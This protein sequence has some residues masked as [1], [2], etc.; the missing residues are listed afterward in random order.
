[1]FPGRSTVAE[2]LLLLHSRHKPRVSLITGVTRPSWISIHNTALKYG[3]NI[4]DFVQDMCIM[5][6]FKPFGRGGGL[7][8]K[9][10]LTLL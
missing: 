1:M 10:C 5:F 3:L 7:V 6:Y 8:V 9:S 2:M 4:S